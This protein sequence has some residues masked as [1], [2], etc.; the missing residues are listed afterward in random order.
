M[1]RL[2]LIAVIGSV[3]RA[4]TAGAPYGR[5]RMA[6]SRARVGVAAGLVLVLSAPALAQSGQIVEYYHLDALG[7]VRVVTDQAGQV[8]ARHDFLPFGEEWNPPANAKEKKL[9]TGHERDSET[10]LDYFGAR[11][12][13]PQMGRFTTVD[14]KR[15]SA[16]LREPQTFNRY[17]YARNSP[18]LYIDPVGLD[19][20]KVFLYNSNAAGNWAKAQ[21][22][23]EKA[24]HTFQIFSGQNSNATNW[25][26]AVGDPAN[27]V[28]YAGHAVTDAEKK[29]SI[30]LSDGYAAGGVTYVEVS[31]GLHVP[32]ATSVVART[33][34]IFGC[35]SV[36][37]GPQY[38]QG[39]FV[40]VDSGPDE[41]T[42]LETLEDAAARFTAT[43][44]EE[45][46]SGAAIDA[47]ANAIFAANS[48]WWGYYP[49][50]RNYDDGRVMTASPGGVKK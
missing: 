29:W 44:A 25:M 23:A 28:I 35:Q 4:L 47:R 27:R 37:L 17:A 14:P 45:R 1:S 46:R 8:I 15:A 30:R 7:S 26:K 38:S 41:G 34:A 5:R 9:F 33:V 50:T 48:A 43:D 49:P 11:Y 22:A 18:L 20:Y 40:G 2:T 24:G 39:F 19:S 12:Y 13:R 21:K 16:R 10:G 42:E 36:Q 3:V 6:V 31:P 32:I